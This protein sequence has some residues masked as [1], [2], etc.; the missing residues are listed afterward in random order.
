MS[1]HNAGSISN[2]VLAIERQDE[3]GDDQ[4]LLRYVKKNGPNDYTLRAWNP[5]YEDMSATNDMRTFARLHSVLDPLE[6]NLHRP[7]MREDIPSLF[8]H[9]FNIGSWNLGHVNPKGSN[10][11]VLLVTLNKT[12][13]SKDHRYLDYFETESV[14]HWQSQNATTPTNKRG[15]SILKQK[16]NG[17]NFYLFVRKN[18]LHGKGAAPFYYCGSL[19]YREHTGSKPM[20][21]TWALDVP[22]SPQLAELFEV[23]SLGRSR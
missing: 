8:G 2:Q 14:F 18:K 9:E 13:Q 20:N 17:E 11:H 4:Y 15:S 23:Q 1:P 5:D 21:V 12:G 22:L 3:F 19:Q 6:F 7:L 16:E 10:E